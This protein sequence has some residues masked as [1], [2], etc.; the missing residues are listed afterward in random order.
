MLRIR[1][2]NTGKETVTA[3]DFVKPV[4][5][6]L[7]TEYS[8]LGPKAI[9]VIVA[10][11]TGGSDPTLTVLPK[12]DGWEMTPMLFNR[13]ESIDLWLVVDATRKVEGTVACHFKGQSRLMRR[14]EKNPL[15]RI[16]QRGSF[17][18][19]LIGAPCGLVFYVWG[20]FYLKLYSVVRDLG[21]ADAVVFLFWTIAGVRKAHQRWFQ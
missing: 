11:K 1:I 19:Q 3:E 4:V 7:T 5:I 13:G 18:A 6:H 20:F 21:L 10:K 2:R 8:F 12:G 16:A 9:G 15:K 17:W 14:T